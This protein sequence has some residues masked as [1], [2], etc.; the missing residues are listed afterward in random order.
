MNIV[1]GPA[2][3][4]QTLLIR[5]IRHEQNTELIRARRHGVAD[6]RL[7]DGPAKICQALNVTGSDNGALLNGRRFILEQP[8]ADLRFEIDA[9]PRIGITKDLHRLWRFV[10]V[11]QAL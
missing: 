9:T 4:C 7:T 8:K 6:S 2:G 10:L 11:G 1:T 5:A 3:S